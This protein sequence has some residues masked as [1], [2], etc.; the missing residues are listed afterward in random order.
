MSFLSFC[1]V[2]VVFQFAGATAPSG[3]L[4]CN[5]SAISR[6]IYAKLFS[7][8]GTTYG[9]GDGSTSFNLP[10]YRGV[11]I[12]GVGTNGTANYG[13]KTGY[14]PSGDAL[15]TKVRDKT[16][17]NNLVN[18]NSS[19]TIPDHSHTLSDQIFGGAAR[20]QDGTVQ[21][22]VTGGWVSGIRGGGSGPQATAN[23][24]SLSGT[25]SAQTISSS[26]TETIPAH[27]TANYII[28]F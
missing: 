16:A 8:L 6:T 14:T 25:A 20:W 15:G 13:G 18:S 10:D 22:D 19:V 5:G 21:S 2:G 9:S 11:F 3:W 24:V 17:K 7:I 1:P 27:Q 28:K 23:S 12:R 26:D 4:L